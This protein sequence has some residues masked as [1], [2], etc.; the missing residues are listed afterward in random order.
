MG[1]LTQT[2]QVVEALRKEGGFAT[3]RRLNEIVDF[4][5]WKTKTP[6]ASVRRIV[7]DCDKLFRVRPGLWALKECREKVYG[8]FQIQPGNKESEERFTHGYYQGLLVEIGRLRQ[9]KTYVPPQDKGRLFLDKPLGD[10]ADTTSL[11]LFT[12]ENLLRKARTIDVIWFNE[13]EM[14]S[15]F[16]EVEHTTNMQNSLSKFYELQDFFADFYIVAS[17]SR[18]REFKDKLH[19]SMFEPIHD[20]VRFLDYEQVTRMHTGLREIENC[21]W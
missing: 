8:R 13:R 5:T 4:A 14:P 11:P 15:S 19:V 17:E 3:L 6:E 7:Q 18:Q 21:R 12:Y 9:R 20:R 16:F 10:L 2:E 1:K